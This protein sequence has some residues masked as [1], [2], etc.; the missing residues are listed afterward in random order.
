M[1]R[2]AAA[3]S[4]PLIQRKLCLERRRTGATPSHIRGPGERRRSLVA[5]STLLALG[6][7]A[8]RAAARDAARS[9]APCS[10]PGPDAEAP[11]SSRSRSFARVVS[12]I[13]IPC[14]KI[15][16][17]E[18]SADR[19][20]EGIRNREVRPWGGEA[21]HEV[22]RA[23][24][25]TR[26][27]PAGA[28]QGA[29][30]WLCSGLYGAAFDCTHRSAGPM[31]FEALRRL[32]SLR[33]AARK[34]GSEEARKRE[35]RALLLGT[36]PLPRSWISHGLHRITPLPRNPSCID[37]LGSGIDVDASLDGGAQFFLAVDVCRLYSEPV[38][39][40]MKTGPAPR[41]ARNSPLA[42]TTP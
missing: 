24:M 22:H 8:D 23:P 6:N 9:S 5:P 7:W 32:T 29:G 36:S 27:S 19:L 4:L 21:R 3:Q 31:N 16:V 20:A 12:Y 40:A 13:G 17:D 10:P 30:G 39:V 34:R 33:R 14:R 26:H 1:A 2:S 25:K 38:G 42:E 28:A 15:S 37:R 41:R 35:G 18:A 11:A